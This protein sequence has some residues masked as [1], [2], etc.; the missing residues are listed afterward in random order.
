LSTYT[1]LEGKGKKRRRG[2]RDAMFLSSPHHHLLTVVRKKK[3]KR[4]QKLPK[5]ARSRKPVLKEGGKG[6]KRGRRKRRDLS[7]V[8]IYCSALLVMGG[9]EGKKYIDDLDFVQVVGA[10]GRRRE[11]RG[12]GGEKRTFRRIRFCKPPPPEK[13]HS[14]SETALL[15]RVGARRRGKKEGKGGGKK[16]KDYF[17]FMLNYDIRLVRSMTACLS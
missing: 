14:G 3:D 17:G 4:T 2:G 7:R 16:R 15:R 5:S 13:G 12:G 1:V 10:R 8:L 11:G 6:K 9:R